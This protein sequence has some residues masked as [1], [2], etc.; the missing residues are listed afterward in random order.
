MCAAEQRENSLAE[1]DLPAA[2]QARQGVAMRF[3]SLLICLSSLGFA[4]TWSGVLVDSRCYTSMWN[5]T[6]PDVPS[7]AR[8]MNSLLVQCAA[9]PDTRRFA[10][11]QYDWRPLR[12]DAAGNER[13]AAIIR[14]IWKRR[15]LYCV[16]VAGARKRNE[17]FAGPVSL[18]S[19]HRQR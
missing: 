12:L 6:G 15:A 4:G 14:P 13:A 3:A 17:I 19:I 9:R 2:N 7:V 1:S 18:A 8:D 16:T 11:V 5:N 10:I